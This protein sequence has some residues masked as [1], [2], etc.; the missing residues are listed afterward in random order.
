MWK[1]LAPHQRHSRNF[2]GRSSQRPHTSPYFY[3]SLL[4][5]RPSPEWFR[6]ELLYMFLQTSMIS[7]WCKTASEPTTLRTQICYR[8][9][10]MQAVPDWAHPSTL[11]LQ[12]EKMA[13]TC[14]RVSRPRSFPLMTEIS[15]DRWRLIFTEISCQVLTWPSVLSQTQRLKRRL[16]LTIASKQ[17]FTRVCANCRNTGWSRKITYVFVFSW[18]INF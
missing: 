14:A 15:D 4:R 16:D 13:R 8:N 7:R 10:H 9:T 12:M 5:M 2:K 1:S 6:R 18:V 3:L 11:S 17:C